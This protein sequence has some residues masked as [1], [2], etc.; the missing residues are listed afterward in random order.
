MSKVR[1]DAAWW[2]NNE[3][4]QTLLVVFGNGEKYFKDVS[5]LPEIAKAILKYNNNLLF[6][7]NLNHLRNLYLIYLYMLHKVTSLPH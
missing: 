3:S 7:T 4:L 6:R 2:V 1:H 5:L